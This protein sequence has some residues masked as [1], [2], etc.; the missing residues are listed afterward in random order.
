MPSLDAI[1]AHQQALGQ[2]VQRLT[3]ELA[4]LR[5]SNP[6][7]RR[8]GDGDHT[9]LSRKPLSGYMYACSLSPHATTSLHVLA[10]ARLIH[11]L[12]LGFAVTARAGILTHC[13]RVY[14]S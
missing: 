5:R 7:M 4:K 6:S 2:H 3:D 11:R 13:T 1:I 12:L 10:G 14:R 8:S 9:L